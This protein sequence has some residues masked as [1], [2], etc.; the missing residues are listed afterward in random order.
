MADGTS[1]T[2]AA[3]E[4]RERIVAVLTAAPGPMTSRQIYNADPDLVDYKQV[5]NAVNH[6]SASGQV[7][8][9]NGG[10]LL[11]GERS[12]AP[13]YGEPAR[14]YPALA[15][16]GRQDY[17]DHAVEDLDT[18]IAVLRRL[19]QLMEPSIAKMLHLIREDLERLSN[20]GQQV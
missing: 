11:G 17:G 13:A 19:E 6:L 7:I 16:L 15:L 9:D 10:Y 5:T 1:S 2:L 14:T 4:V 12:R 8:R 20:G 3:Q 18:K